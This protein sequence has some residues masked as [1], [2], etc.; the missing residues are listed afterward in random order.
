[1]DVDPSEVHA[2]DAIEEGEHAKPHARAN[3]AALSASD[4]GTV[5]SGR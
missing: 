2:Y 5:G 4:P 1:M 3:A